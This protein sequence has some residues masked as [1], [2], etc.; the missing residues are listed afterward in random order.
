MNARPAARLLLTPFP[1]L[2]LHA[3]PLHAQSDP[4]P[5]RELI[6]SFRPGTFTAS[7]EGTDGSL[8]AF[9]CAAPELCLLLKAAGVE[10]VVPLLPDFERE[11]AFA[12]TDSGIVR[13]TDWSDTYVLGLPTEAAL[14]ALLAALVE[15]PDV[16]Y[17]EPNGRAAHDALGFPDA[18]PY[19]E[20]TPPLPLAMVASLI[21]NDQ[22]L[23][24]QWTFCTTGFIPS[25][26]R[27]YRQWEFCNNAT[28]NQGSGT[29]DA[30]VDATEA[31]AKETGE[32]WVKIG[33]VDYGIQVDHPDFAG[34]VTGDLTRDPHG[35]AVAG[36]AAAQGNNGIGVAGMVWNALIINEDFDPATIPDVVAAFR[37]AVSLGAHVINNSWKLT[38]AEGYP[39]TL[40]RAFANAYRLGRTAVASM[41]NGG[42]YSLQYPA[43]Y[44][45]GVITVGATLNTDERAPYSSWGDWIDVTAPG[46][47]DPL[48]VREDAIYTTTISPTYYDYF[49]GTSAAAP[50]VSG[51]AA[52]LISYRADLQDH[53]DDVEELIERSAEDKGT[54]GF[55]TRFGWGRVNAF[56]ALTLLDAPNVLT[57]ATVNGGGTVTSVSAQ[58]D[59]RIY[60]PNDNL[61]DGLYLAKR[62]EVRRT[63]SIGPYQ[64][65]PRAWGRGGGLTVAPT[66]G[67]GEETDA[68]GLRYTYGMPLTEVVS[69]SALALTLRTYIYEVRDDQG[70]FYGY[71][72]T[73]P[74]NAGFA[75]TV[76][77]VPCQTVCSGSLLAD[78]A[79]P[80]FAVERVVPNPVR[81]AAEV[82]Y[83]LPEAAEVVLTLHDALGREVVRLPA[84]P[85]EAGWHRAALDAS[86]LAAGVYV[87]R[88]AA[89][90]HGGTARVTVLRR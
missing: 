61:A 14:E 24:R 26:A 13:L 15:H 83:V 55:D 65:T 76:L 47:N 88:V 86:G 39:I 75:Y 57:R 71:Y 16:A 52:L 67:W 42:G 49:N 79:A 62:H 32:S 74:A 69:V 4:D 53:P 82:A 1:L 54:V 59:L 48:I 37:S 2:A 20:T 68:G 27:F 58:Y 84:E 64:T 35:T 28:E 41:G 8:D 85:Q 70:T 17:T 19:A 7:G 50:V 66:V 80:A 36:I 87:V 30:D 11:D 21:P 25:D 18:A 56:Q 12:E 5:N 90:R 63:V 60:N 10:H 31:W 73:P 29:A 43:G 34:R 72:P 40:R 44:R 23:Y 89:G 3:L 45:Q 51:L 6:A 9:A 33:V 22:Q 81:G 78:E 77:G 38:Q 46:G